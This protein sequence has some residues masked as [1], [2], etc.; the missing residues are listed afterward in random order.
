MRR[1]PK[2]DGT[3][4][5]DCIPQRGPC[6][7]QCNQCFYNHAFYLSIDRSHFPTLEEVGDGIVQ[8]NSG[9]DSNINRD[10]VIES[11]KQYPKRFFNTSIP[12]FDFPAPVVFTA[13][14]VEEGT[15]YLPNQCN[16]SDLEKI[17]FVRLRVSSTNLL[18]ILDA[19]IKWSMASIPVVLT[20]M[21]YYED[22]PDLVN[23]EF[24][25][26]IKNDYWCPTKIFM[27]LVM[28][29]A[30]SLEANPFI[31]MCGTPKS[32]YCRDCLNCER[33]Y[34]RALSL[35]NTATYIIRDT[36]KT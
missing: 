9:H 3:K 36:K 6:P 7:N 17:M 8:V 11:T 32:S 14:P 10:H 20:F 28:Q 1:N 2:Q 23:Y 16:R 27:M 13:N 12:E 30:Q 26:S 19:A 18:H 5:F 35:G 22:P 34:Y 33:Y 4:L 24:R 15:P 29:I 25:K 31:T 21:R